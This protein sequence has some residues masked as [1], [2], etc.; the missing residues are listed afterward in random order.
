MIDALGHDFAKDFTVDA[1]ATC[2]NVGSKS[3]HCIRCDA[4]TDVTEIPAS[5]HNMKKF[6]QKKL[7]K[8]KPEISN[9]MSAVSVRNISQM[10]QHKM[11]SQ[12]KQAL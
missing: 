9:I 11:R 1:E 10:R 2:K 5:G 8:K 6:L 4:K 12:T 7:P 3:R